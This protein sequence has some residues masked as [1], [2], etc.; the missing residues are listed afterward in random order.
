MK[1]IQTVN[2]CIEFSEEHY[3]LYFICTFSVSCIFLNIYGNM[4]SQLNFSGAVFT[5]KSVFQQEKEIVP[6]LT[7]VNYNCAKFQMFLNFRVTELFLLVFF[8]EWMVTTQFHFGWFVWNKFNGIEIL[9]WNLFLEHDRCFFVV[10][11]AQIFA[12]TKVNLAC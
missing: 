5:P 2:I 3:N 8:N 12:A 6:L 1:I 9:Q 10:T 4:N 7:S 11:F